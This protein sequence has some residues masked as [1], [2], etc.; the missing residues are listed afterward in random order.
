[1]IKSSRWYWRWGV[2]AL[3]MVLVAGLMTFV[4]WPG[5]KTPPQLA[6]AATKSLRAWRG[7]TYAGITV[8]GNGAIIGFRLTVARDGTTYGTLSRDSGAYA[9]LAVSPRRTLLRGNSQWWFEHEPGSAEALAH[10]WVADP[11]QGVIGLAELSRMTPTALADALSGKDTDGPSGRPSTWRQSGATSV[12]GRPAKGTDRRHPAHR[13]ECVP[14]VP[15]AIGRPAGFRWISRSRH[16]QTCA[17]RLGC[18]HCRLPLR[19]AGRC[20]TVR[21]PCAVRRSGADGGR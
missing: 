7:V 9:E 12:N 17:G 5:E 3:V 18:A 21:A 16:T 1:M 2:L 15:A 13:G 10:I 4:L 6:S 19:P 14:S 8:N 11:P 20:R